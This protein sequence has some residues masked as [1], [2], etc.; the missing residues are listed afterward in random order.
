MTFQYQALPSAAVEALKQGGP[1]S[2]GQKAELAHS[3]GSGNPCRHCLQEIMPGEA[4][5]IDVAELHV[6]VNNQ[7]AIRFYTRHGFQVM[8]T[9]EG[10]YPRLDPSDA[11]RLEKQLT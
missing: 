2:N 1:D 4:C 8:E 5:S 10:Y 9:C 7:D 6:Q 3:D 11:V